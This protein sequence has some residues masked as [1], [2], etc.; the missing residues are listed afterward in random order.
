MSGWKNLK[1][2]SILA[3]LWHSILAHYDTPQPTTIIFLAT[4]SESCDT[5]PLDIEDVT[6]VCT[7]IISHTQIYPWYSKNEP[8]FVLHGTCVYR[9]AKTTW[10]I[11]FLSFVKRDFHVCSSKKLL[12]TQASSSIL[13]KYDV[14][15]VC[16][17]RTPFHFLVGVSFK[18]KSILTILLSILNPSRTPKPAYVHVTLQRT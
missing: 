16:I 6:P 1:G 2:N 7:C 18:C 13:S 4:S 3:G 11:F 15:S 9:Q 12:A 10:Q 5:L 17:P 14:P 8:R